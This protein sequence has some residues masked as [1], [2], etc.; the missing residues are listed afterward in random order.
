MINNYFNMNY[1]QNIDKPFLKQTKNILYQ[2]YKKIKLGNELAHNLNINIS[3][4]EQIKNIIIHE[5]EDTG[6]LTLLDF[7][8]SSNGD[9]TIKKLIKNRKDNFY[10]Y[11]NMIKNE[12]KLL[13]T[14]P[15]ISIVLKE[16]LVE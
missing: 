15:K 7:I 1:S 12:T 9:E 5:K 8:K 3:V 16:K 6:L 10:N 2:I 13:S 4:I 11:E 14:V